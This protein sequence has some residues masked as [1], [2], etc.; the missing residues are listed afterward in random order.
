MAVT[1]EPLAPE[2]LALISYIAEDQGRAVK[3]ARFLLDKGLKQ[4]SKD[5]GG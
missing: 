1:E 3:L 2:Q 5:E 4:L